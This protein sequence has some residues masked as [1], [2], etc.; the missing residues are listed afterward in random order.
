MTTPLRA[1]RD[2]FGWKSALVCRRIQSLA[3]RRGLVVA[4][5]S[6]LKTM[7]SRWENGRGT[8]DPETYQPLL[9]EI[10]GRSPFDLGFDHGGAP[11]S[12]FDAAGELAERIT[13]ASAVD[14]ETIQLLNRQTNYLRALDRKVGGV[15]LAEQM[16]AHLGALEQLISFG[17]LR[18]SRRGLAAV[19][20]DAAALAGWQA[21]D[22]GL[23]LEAWRHHETARSAANEAE[24]PALLAHAMAEQAFELIDLN[25]PDDAVVLVEEALSVAKLGVPRLLASW[26]RAAEG[27]VHAAAGHQIECQRAFDEALTL[28]PSDVTDPELPYLSLSEG[29]L[30]RWRGNALARLGDDT[31]IGPL[32]DALDQADDT[33]STRARAALH[34]DL[35]V[36]LTA[37]GHQD[38]AEIQ[39]REASELATRIGSARQQRRIHRLVASL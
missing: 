24:S 5:E 4:S 38:E 12:S 10:Y 11:S 31:A 18:A 30:A 20:S 8:P 29:H 21:L 25:R 2:E 3:S 37:G 32:Y 33:L 26:L 7:L 23:A 6:S 13:G 39:V 1:A 17:V 22:R 35:A 16:R 14:A 9:C 36:A 15:I 34:T 27:E 28:L 19:L